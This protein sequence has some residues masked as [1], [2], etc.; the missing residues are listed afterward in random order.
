[1][2]RPKVKCNEQSRSPALVDPSMSSFAVLDVLAAALSLEA[3]KKQIREGID[4]EI[5]V[6]GI[7]LNS[8][9]RILDVFKGIKMEREV[10]NVPGHDGRV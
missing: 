6:S 3:L 5:V 9:E 10:K 1:M 7:L 4:R 2:E 8:N